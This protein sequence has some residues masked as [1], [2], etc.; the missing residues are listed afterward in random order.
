MTLSR[1]AISPN[2]VA[3]SSNVDG[4]STALVPSF[5]HVA[6]KP[7]RP[8][9]SSPSSGEL[10]SEVAGCRLALL[11]P[12]S[13]LAYSSASGSTTIA[14]TRMVPPVSALGLL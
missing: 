12:T 10:V 7:G 2:P 8:S 6:T 5:F 9:V 13:Q 14:L 1:N 3:L 4:P 11:H